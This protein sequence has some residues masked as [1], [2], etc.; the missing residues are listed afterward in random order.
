MLA[1][2]D[3]GEK[4]PDDKLDKIFERFYQTASATNERQAGTGIGLDLTRSLVELHHGTI[5]AHNN[6]NGKG[7]T[8]VVTL[9]LGRAH[10]KPEEMVAE[11]TG[12]NEPLY[13][14]S[15]EDDYI[16][17]EPIEHKPPVVTMNKKRP[18][19]IIA[20]DDSE[21][22]QYLNSELEA[23]YRIIVCSNGKKE[24]LAAVLKEIPALVISDIM[25]PEMDGNTSLYQNQVECQYQSD[26]RHIAYGQKPG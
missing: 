17:T 21:I 9:P 24:A 12:G 6:E 26:T 16:G 13:G 11:E 4:I 22:C 3:D 23:E 18:L 19:I 2:S 25:M 20:E 10:L 15:L 14:I 8:F 5:K 1:V 7:C